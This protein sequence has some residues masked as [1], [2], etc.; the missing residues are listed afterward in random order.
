M[1]K[2]CINLAFLAFLLT[3][4]ISQATASDFDVIKKRV[5][6]NLLGQ[7]VPDKAVETMV[8]TINPD[9]TWSHIDY[10]DVSNEGFQHSEHAANMVTMARAYKKKGS[11]FYKSKKVKQAITLAFKHW[12]ENDYICK[13]WW[14]NEVGTPTNLVNLML[15]IGDEL[16]KDLVEKGQ[17]IIGRAHIN[18]PGAR[19][20]GDRIKIAGIQAKN[21]LFT[22]DSQ[23]FNEVIKV[24]ENEIKS[25]EWIGREYGYTFKRHEGGF[26]NRSSGGRGIQYDNSFHHRTDGV[27][28]TL[29]Y[30]MGYAEAFI[31]W[32]VYTAGTSYAFSGEK[33]EKLVDYYLDGICKT[34]VFGKYPDPGKKNRSI[35]RRGD[36]RPYSAKSAENLLKTTN[37]RRAELQDIADIRNNGIKPTLSHATFFWNTEHFTFQRPDWFTSVR[38][39]ST[40]TH[41]MEE[42]YNSEGLLNHHRGDGANHISRTGDE[43]YDIF[44]VFDY[45]MIP[46]AT[47]MQKESLPGPGQIQ[48]LG[49]THFVGAVTDG[50]YGAV[51]FDFKSP[52]DPLIARKSW[53]FFDDAYVALGTGISCTQQLPVV[54]TLNQCLLRGGVILSTEG[55]QSVLSRGENNYDNVDWVFHDG[56]GYLFPQKTSVGLKNDSVTGSWWNL[57]KQTSTDKSPVTKDIF[58]LW[59]DHGKRPSDELYAYIVVPATTP[60]KMRQLR[61]E[62]HIDIL[63]N[64]PE[65]QAVKNKDLEITQAVFYRGGEIT[66]HENLQLSSD[67]QGIVMV[68]MKEGRL[69]EIS[70]SDP[71]REL[72][73]FNL[74]V[75]TRIDK[76]GSNF[77]TV[78]NEDEQATHISIALPQD[79]YAGD[80]VTIQLNE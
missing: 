21:M 50:T 77:W 6:A 12:V 33:I 35:S 15:L 41:N 37:Y 59:I 34:A 28:N 7:D 74:S 55:K 31:E 14:H 53:F 9:G 65:I 52:H 13:N 67:N 66:I 72:E 26:S 45:Q 63:M 64:S 20:G 17:P 19:P 27:N 54:T 80:S 73:R 25:V 49:Q 8:N 30:G 42:P 57:S 2:I 23:T 29:S 47:I 38:M 22:G 10:E 62:S 4:H 70:V 11:A 16:P 71:S 18:G 60:E 79:N 40:R 78:W 32:A 44:P 3:F 36:L 43:Y 24:I 68:K 75:T 69:A 56:I 39:Y 51:A 48:K 5:I 58:K 61:S 76:K 1:K 46:G